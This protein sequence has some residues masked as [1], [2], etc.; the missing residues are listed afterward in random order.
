MIFEEARDTLPEAFAVNSAILPV[1]KQDI[2][3]AS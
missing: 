1:V 2:T 3:T